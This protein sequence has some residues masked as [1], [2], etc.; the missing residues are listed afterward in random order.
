MSPSG[1]GTVLQIASSSNFWHI[2]GAQKTSVEG[3]KEG[4]KERGKG[5]EGHGER[6][7]AGYF[8]APKDQVDQSL[9]S[10]PFCLRRRQLEGG[11]HCSGTSSS[12]SHLAALPRL[13]PLHSHLDPYLRGS[14]NFSRTQLSTSGFD[15][16]HDGPLPSGALRA[17]LQKCC[18]LH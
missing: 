11:T 18:G 6:K 10:G 8:G 1:E 5:K 4:G 14:R 3:G 12:G 9:G 15:T 7:E 16:T 17:P 13:W 2:V